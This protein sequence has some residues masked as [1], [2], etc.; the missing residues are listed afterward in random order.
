MELWK[1][2]AQLFIFIFR[3][4]I[5]IEVYLIYSVVII[6]AVQQSDSVIRVHISILSSFIKLKKFYCFFSFHKSLLSPPHCSLFAV[7]PTS[8]FAEKIDVS[9]QCRSL[10]A[11][12][13][14]FKMPSI[15]L[16]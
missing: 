9:W 11:K 7:N 15:I 4:F 8:Y 5:F 13:L 2:L 10:A 6:S 1:S 3:I 12:I 14:N 16:S